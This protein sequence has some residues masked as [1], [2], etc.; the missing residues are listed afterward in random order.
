[1]T[2]KLGGSEWLDLR[3]V[4]KSPEILHSNQNWLI[5]AESEQPANM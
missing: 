4:I 3:E 2:A 5:S 1:M